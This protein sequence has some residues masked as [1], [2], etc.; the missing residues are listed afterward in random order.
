[1]V[2]NLDWT[3]RMSA[4]EFLRDVGKH[5]PVNKMLAREVVT[6]GWRPASASPSSATSSAVHDYYELHQRYGCTLQFGGSDQWGNITAGVGLH[7]PPRG[8]PV[9][10]FTTPLVTQGGRDQV[11]QDRRRFRLAGPGAHVAVRL[12][13]VLGQ[14]SDADVSG[15]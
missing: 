9:H 12:L 7:P 4:I 3:E 6:A 2:N 8:G 5:F 13:P 1:M 15:T 14:H 11:R 10:A